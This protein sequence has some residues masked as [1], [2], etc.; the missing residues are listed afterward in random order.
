MKAGA[1]PDFMGS[2]RRRENAGTGGKPMLWEALKRLF[3]EDF[4]PHGHCYFWE[5]GLVWLQVLSNLAI[6]V[7]YLSISLTLAYVVRHI[8]DIPFQW[9]YL[10]F[11]VFI[12]TCGFTHFM[13]VWVIW[14]PVYWLD[15]SIRAVT[16]VASVGTALLL[17][18]LVPKAVALAG[19]ARLAHERG[20]RVEQLNVELAALY[21]NAR[22]TLAEAIPHLVWTTSPDGTLDYCNRRCIEYAGTKQEG[23]LE[24]GFHTLVHPD[25]V[26]R[27]LTQWRESLRTGEAYGVECRLRRHDDVYR[28]FLVR[29][30]P[31]EDK[32]GRI[33]KWFGT[34]TD[35]EEQKQAAEE[36]ER[37]L[38][39]TQE[40]VRSR[41][42]FLAI[43]AHELKTPLTPLRFEAQRLLDAAREGQ[44]DRLTP[45]R[46]ERRLAVLE[47]QT[48]RL[49][50]LVH[51]LLDVARIAGGKLEF[52]L[53]DVDL[54]EI[55]REVVHRHE[56]AM[57]REGIGLELHVEPGVVGRWDRLRL[58][59]VVTNLLTNAL[60]YG[61]GHPITV[62]VEARG[63]LAVL[64]VKDRGIGIAKAD[65]PR[66]FERFERAAS[67]RHYGG[68]G[69]G[70]WL[71]RQLVEALG[72]AIRVESELG[73]GAVFTVELPRRPGSTV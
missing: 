46:L 58:D 24:K 47:R 13:D 14:T 63:D 9:M 61:Q 68:L 11:G 31:L 67:E 66:I 39:K 57:E 4:M 23:E 48:G 60:K 38:A 19:A 51:V 70:L 33:V 20:V 36:R 65:Q 12:I 26:E 55:V 18:P 5:P 54:G 10:C 25:D 43:A 53:A 50:E 21:E 69:L 22:E 37:L 45:E 2:T 27:V 62:E 7:A 30:L 34:C 56:Q 32:H 44:R 73:I 6:G 3:S 40:A 28:W 42:V 29:G 8:R 35:M 16:A 59:Q 71:A 41:D 72:G 15:G 49:E 64:R 17:F 1:S 52:T